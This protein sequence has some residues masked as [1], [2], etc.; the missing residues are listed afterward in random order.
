MRPGQHQLAVVAPLYRER[1]FRGHHYDDCTPAGANV[2]Q[3]N[4]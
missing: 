3:E 1:H 4:L 2:T